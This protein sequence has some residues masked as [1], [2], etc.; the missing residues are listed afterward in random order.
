MK[1]SQDRDKG[2]VTLTGDV[3][4]DSDKAQAESIAKSAAAGEVVSNQIAVVPSSDREANKVN[5]D[6]DEG[7][8]KNLD[9]ALVRD[10]LKHDVSYDVKNGVVT[11]TGTVPSERRRGTRNEW[12]RTFRT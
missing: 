9:A 11:L 6:L 8:E 5:S 1:V 3:Q 4:S 10:K 2:I 12:P 7:I